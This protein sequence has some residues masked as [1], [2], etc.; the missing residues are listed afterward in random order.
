MAFYSAS[1][2]SPRQL[3]LDLDLEDAPSAL[4]SDSGVKRSVIFPK[5]IQ[6]FNVPEFQRQVSQLFEPLN[7]NIEFRVTRQ[8]RLEMRWSFPQEAIQYN[9]SNAR[10]GSHQLARLSPE[11]NAAFET[12]VLSFAG[13]SH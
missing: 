3:S 2:S 10:S 12:L 9:H 1:S 4:S 8:N 11:E 5:N 6:I 13:S 7:I